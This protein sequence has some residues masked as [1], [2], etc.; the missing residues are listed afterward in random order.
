MSLCYVYYRIVY[1]FM[2]Y[3]CQNFMILL[4]NVFIMYPH[5]NCSDLDRFS[6]TVILLIRITRINVLKDKKGSVQCYYFV[7]KGAI[8]NRGI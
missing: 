1:I 6:Y 8:V 3:Y 4:P 2:P 7:P 5:N